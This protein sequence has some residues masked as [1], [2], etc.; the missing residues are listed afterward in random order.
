MLSQPIESRERLV[1]ART[2]MADLAGVVGLL[3][4]FTVVCSGKGSAAKGAFE[5]TFV[6]V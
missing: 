3:M 5:G 1:A 6:G 2:E 4:A